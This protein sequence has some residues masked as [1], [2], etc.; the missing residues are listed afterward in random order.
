[1]LSTYIFALIPNKLCICCLLF[2]IRLT[3]SPADFIE[4]VAVPLSTMAKSWPWPVSDNLVYQE[5]SKIILRN[6]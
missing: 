6:D 2:R 5:L 3:D 1:M 4:V